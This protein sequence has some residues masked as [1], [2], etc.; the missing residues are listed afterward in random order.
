M[1][2]SSVI[3]ILSVGGLVVFLLVMRLA[4][5]PFFSFPVSPILSERTT[6][7]ER[8]WVPR[9]HGAL[10]RL[11]VPPR[12]S[13]ELAGWS[14]RSVDRDPVMTVRIED[15]SPDGRISG[16]ITGTPGTLEVAC[17]LRTS[18]RLMQGWIT[19]TPHGGPSM[20]L[21]A[22]DSLVLHPGFTGD[23]Q[24]ETV[25]VLNFEVLLI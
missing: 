23:W 19:L 11:P 10:A 25:A 8:A 1:D 20:T 5:G 6:E 16:H 13:D 24:N 15:Q 7:P 4:L 14:W 17:K 9:A 2:R 22:G 21:K 12:V 3:L 18:L